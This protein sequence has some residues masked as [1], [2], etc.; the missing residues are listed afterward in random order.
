[1]NSVPTLIYVGNPVP[2]Y[3]RVHSL[4]QVNISQNVSSMT[5]LFH[6]DNTT[7][8]KAIAIKLLSTL[9]LSY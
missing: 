4:F 9:L 7:K 1:M 8:R 5:P 6:K 2:H 3:D